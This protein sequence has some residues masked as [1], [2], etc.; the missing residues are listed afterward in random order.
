MWE[1][2]RLCMYLTSKEA[3]AGAEAHTCVR[4][5]CVDGHPDH[6]P[7]SSLRFPPGGRARL[8][9]QSRAGCLEM[10]RSRAAP[11]PGGLWSSQSP[12]AGAPCL[13][14]GLLWMESSVTTPPWN[15]GDN[16][17]V[18]HQVTHFL[19]K[20]PHCAARWLSTW[21]W[22]KPRGARGVRHTPDFKALA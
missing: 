14:G 4:A 6:L 22:S 17:T 5:E 15:Q 7:A 3:S 10:P 8:T 13:T 9:P 21:G 18:E 1:F 19:W 2:R 16:T 20:Q 11:L 12:W